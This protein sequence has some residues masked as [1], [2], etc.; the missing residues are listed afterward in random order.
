[1][2][3]SFANAVDF[4]VPPSSHS[5]NSPTAPRLEYFES[6]SDELRRVTIEHSP[7]KIGRCETSDLRIDSAQVSREHA[8]IYRRG[9]IWAIRDLG[10]TNGTQVNGKPVRESFL[11]DGDVLAIA[12]TEVTFVASAATPFQRMATQP[13]QSRQSSATPAMLPSEIAVVRAMTEATLWQAIPLQIA[14]CVSLASGEVEAC[15][16]QCSHTTSRADTEFHPSAGHTLGRHFRD[17]ARRRT[18][19]MAQDQS[20]AKRI[21]VAAD[22]AEFESPQQFLASLNEFR[23][24]MPLD[25]EMGVAISLSGNLDP[26]ALND[27]CGAVRKAQ[28]MLA[29]VGFQGSSGQVSELASAAPEYL[30]LSDTMLK[31]VTAG[32]QPLR[33]LQQVLAACQQFGIAAVL[34]HFACQRTIAQCRQLGYE[35]AIQLAT[36]QENADCGDLVALAG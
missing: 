8:Q 15:W 6:G 18:I 32:S 26:T 29:L 21:F 14:M 27:A 1:M 13:I 36:P 22:V 16:A 19:E 33:R 31:G 35:L 2:A 9:S 30:L 24:G 20:M 17:L 3:S 34:P 10:S 11:S 23:D 25:C 12:E 28:L 7:F 4:A 5:G